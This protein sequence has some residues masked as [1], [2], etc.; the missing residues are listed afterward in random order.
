MKPI[1]ISG[2]PGAGK[3]TLVNGLAEQ[4]FATFE[5]SSRRLIEQES[6]KP[7]GILPWVDLAAFAKLCLDVMSEQKIQASTHDVAFLDRAIPDICGYLRQGDLNVDEHYLEA[8]K[9]YH[10]QAFLCRPEASIYVQDEVRPYPF[11]GAIE[12]HNA[13][14]EVYQTLGFEV[15]DVP[16]MS[17]EE[18]VQFVQQHIED[19]AK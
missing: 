13:L 3:T 11:E 10:P 1:I 18:R 12:I 16:F 14:V 8:S 9:G 2:G 17:I 15:I 7:D 5:E 6:Q 19:V 4:G